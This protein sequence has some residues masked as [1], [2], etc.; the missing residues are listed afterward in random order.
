MRF[1]GI[2]KEEL[3]TGWA[4]LYNS[5][6][7]TTVRELSHVSRVAVDR[8]MQLEHHRRLPR[9]EKVSISG[10]EA[11]LELLELL[12][13]ASHRDAL[14]SLDF[15]VKHDVDEKTAKLLTRVIR[16]STRWTDV[17]IQ[18]SGAS[19]LQSEMLVH[20]GQK[21]HDVSRVDVGA[22]FPDLTGDILA[23][24]LAG[25]RNAD[26]V[27]LLPPEDQYYKVPSNGMILRKHLLKASERC[28]QVEV[29][30]CYMTAI[31]EED[32]ADLSRI[33]LLIQ[34]NG[35]RGVVAFGL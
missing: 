34:T 11:H 27:K 3:L 6:A 32:A 15:F 8:K 18:F 12:T 23:T 16:N 5:P 13:D 25:T 9:L 19:G 4:A 28:R 30:C 21:C 26:A 24:F 1:D 14:R 22:W 2:E 17:N 31:T 20:L 35:K 33:Q 29:I 7:A 10:V